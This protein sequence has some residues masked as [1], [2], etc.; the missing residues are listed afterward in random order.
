MV[1]DPDGGSLRKLTDG[2]FHD[3]WPCP[4]PDGGLAFITTRCKERFLCW[5]PQAAVLFRMNT[6]GTGI[7]PLSYAN[8]TEWAPSVM[9][10][11]RI[12]W[13]RS[14]TRTR[15][16][17][18]AH[19]LEHPS[20]WH[21]TGTGFGNDII[22]PNGYANGQEVPETNEICCTFISHFATSMV[23]S[24]SWTS[25]RDGSIRKRSPA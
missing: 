10:D 17:F 21:E 19:P 20:R 9:N 22:Q 5:R 7:R 14:S 23:P 15:G 2:P 1:M 16:R 8:L 12:I 6:D 11:G 25:T 24:L 3:Y 18:R 4:L 13:T